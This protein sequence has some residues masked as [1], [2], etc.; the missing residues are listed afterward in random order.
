MVSW[1]L[2]EGPGCCVPVL[3]DESIIPL[4]AVDPGEPGRDP[5]FV[6]IEFGQGCE[7]DAH[8]VDSLQAIAVVPADA[9]L[10]SFLATR[11][12]KPATTW[13]IGHDPEAFDG[14][15]FLTHPNTTGRY[16]ARG[17]GLRAVVL[18]PLVRDDLRPVSVLDDE[19]FVVDEAS[20]LGGRPY[21]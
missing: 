3:F 1:G 18:V 11:Y 16:R 9:F 12:D 20:I 4:V 14:F 13:I 15:R 10:R 5:P 19:A 6:R 21:A 2:K 8:Q 7:A 17:D